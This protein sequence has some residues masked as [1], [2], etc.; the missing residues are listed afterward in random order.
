MATEKEDLQ[1]DALTSRNCFRVLRNASRRPP[2]GG[3]L[4]GNMSR[5][6]LVFLI[7]IIA[8]PT[9]LPADTA[10]QA[11]SRVPSESL[12]DP[13]FGLTVE[14][15]RQRYEPLPSRV[16]QTCPTLRRGRHWVFASHRT[17]DTE[18]L[19]VSGFIAGADSDP[20][21]NLIVIR[22]RSCTGEGAD[23]AFAT[24][25]P[26]DG[27]G[28]DTTTYLLPG[29]GAPKVCDAHGDCRYTLRSRN[30]EDIVRGLARDALTRGTGAWGTVAFRRRVCDSETRA[31][32][33][34]WSQILGEEV[35][36]FCVAR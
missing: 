3:P 12:E 6:T 28:A 30:E 34:A 20:L 1:Y 26:K 17:G 27:Y 25:V 8:L 13:V 36:A 2:N 19:I 10:A 35:E 31:S 16:L 21:G 4:R 5:N 9:V 14:L 7:C 18:Y 29:K 32:I 23:W 24:V 33:T 11:Q 22:G 15:D